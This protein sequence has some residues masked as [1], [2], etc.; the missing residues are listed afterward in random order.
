L[1]VDVCLD[2]SIGFKKMF[3]RL[4]K[5]QFDL[6]VIL[7]KNELDGGF[8]K[9]KNLKTGIEILVNESYNTVT[10]SSL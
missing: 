6:A 10:A 8:Y 9:V 7:G 1:I 4:D 2:P 5:M 3:K